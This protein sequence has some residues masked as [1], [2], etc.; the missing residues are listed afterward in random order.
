MAT[1]LRIYTINKG[2]L[3]QFAAEWR[4]MIAP[5]RQKLGFEIPGAW[6]NEA[7]N[8]FVWLLRYDG[9]GA[10]E[11]QDNSY[12]ASEE[13]KAASPDPARLIARVEA[14]FVEAVE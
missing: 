14:Y 9:P 3:N 11:E 1:Q 7:T 12:F 8:Q 5:L 4:D 13:R 10:W 6:T 2:S